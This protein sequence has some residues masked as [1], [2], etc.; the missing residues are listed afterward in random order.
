MAAVVPPR[1]PTLE[2]VAPDIAFQRQQ[3]KRQLPIDVL[4][5]LVSG[6]AGITSKQAS[7]SIVKQAIK[8]IA[9]LLGRKEALRRA[10]TSLRGVAMMPEEYLEPFKAIKYQDLPAGVRARYVE[11]GKGGRLPVTSRETWISTLEEP[12]ITSIPHEVGGHYP[13]YVPQ[14][15]QMKTLLKPL[16]REEIIA[17]AGGKSVGYM[18]LTEKHARETTRRMVRESMKGTRGKRPRRLTKKQVDDIFEASL[19]AVLESE[20]WVP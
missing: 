13:Q 6:G 5:T 4:L 16:A 11:F 19:K 15:P 3:A 2:E 14:S 9:P 20:G 12:S 17:Q 8:K 7:R 10:R 1:D 18:S